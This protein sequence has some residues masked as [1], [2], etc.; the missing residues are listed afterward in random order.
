[1]LHKMLFFTGVICAILF[2]AAYTQGAFDVT[3]GQ[4]QPYGLIPLT[5]A[6]AKGEQD[7]TLW[8]N[9]YKSILKLDAD[10]SKN[11]DWLDEKKREVLLK[12]KLEEYNCNYNVKQ[13]NLGHY[14]NRFYSVLSGV[15]STGATDWTCKF[16]YMKNPQ[17]NKDI[18]PNKKRIGS[19]RFSMSG[20]RVTG[21]FSA[22]GGVTGRLDG[23]LSEAAIEYTMA[24]TNGKSRSGKLEV[25]NPGYIFGTWQDDPGRPNDA[26]G[27][28]EFFKQFE[29]QEKQ[30]QKKKTD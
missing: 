23:T 30:I 28:W 2:T 15:R 27:E 21:E 20:N 4:Y 29:Y 26:R 6:P 22:P 18:G 10:L 5:E 1:M 9:A 25:R 19:M 17:D 11:P 12:N 7:S 8:E 24:L 14:G 3:Q 13:F 16:W